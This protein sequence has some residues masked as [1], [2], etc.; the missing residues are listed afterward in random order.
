[1]GKVI[2]LNKAMRQAQA[3]LLREGAG[4]GPSAL[5]AEDIKVRVQARMEDFV[6]MLYGGRAVI[7]RGE[8]RIGSPDG[9]KGSS[10]AINM[11]GENAGVWTDFANK[12]SGNLFDLYAIYMGLDRNRDFQRILA[13]IARDFLGDQVVV[14]EGSGRPWG[15]PTPGEKIAA[16]RAKYGDKP[17]PTTVE[18][19]PPS[20]TWR[21][22]GLDGRVLA[23]VRRYE[24]DEIDP[25][26]G[27]RKKTFRPFHDGRMG[28]PSVRPL[29][30][31]PQIFAAPEVVLVAGEKCADALAAIG[32]EATTIMM[33]ENAPL[34]RVDWNPLRGKTVTVWPDNDQTGRAFAQ[35]VCAVLAGP[36]LGCR[37][38]LVELPAGKPSK[39]DAA[40]MLEEGE[41]PWPL[42]REAREWVSGNGSETLGNVGPF[43]LID[44]DELESLPPPEW[45]VHGLVPAHGFSVL[46]G[47][48]GARKSFLALDMA[49]CVASG[50]DWH[51][52]AVKPGCVIYL[53][54][55]G[56]SG[57]KARIAAWRKSRGPEL[58]KP[59]LKL[60]LQRANLITQLQ[61]LIAAIKGLG[62]EVVFIVIDTLARTFGGAD[63]NNQKDMNAFVSAVDALREATGAHVMIVHHSGKDDSKGARGSSVLLGACDAEFEVRKKGNDELILRTT[64]QKD[65]EEAK[66]IKL[67]AARVEVVVGEETLVSNVLVSDT[68][69][70]PERGEGEGQEGGR[71]DGPD[72]DLEPARK[73]GLGA[74]ERAVLDALEKLG[75]DDDGIGL[76]RLMAMTGRPKNNLS[77]AIGSLLDVGMITK[78]V[79]PIT[80]TP[81]YNLPK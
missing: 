28:A 5:D 12:S 66:P 19:G 72:E 50:H 45:L 58:G 80:G 30:R 59:N 67:R 40:D 57:M 44:V 65:A 11:T 15:E 32:I 69:P 6:R 17:D 29:Y 24:L 61:D 36:S 37:V 8:A 75:P 53:A 10:C 26:T 70:G 56:Q 38:R 48:P 73:R 55:E 79:Q 43:R 74:N 25:V 22:Y 51:G 64:K 41:D 14:P 21:Y 54:A 68:R 9:E 35:R 34:D 60:I 46:Y 7:R 1:M 31:M 18:L 76:L 42:L 77:R 63:E 47:K 16:K 39:W 49:L 71:E 3:D 81:L 13:E 2:D 52:R 20:M 4:R 78:T 27:K 62:E 23:Q 33:G